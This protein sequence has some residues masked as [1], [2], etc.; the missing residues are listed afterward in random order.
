M[1]E[2]A[3]AYFRYLDEGLAVAARS[4]ASLDVC[5]GAEVAFCD[6]AESLGAMVASRKRELAFSLGGMGTASTNFYND[7][8]SR[9][10]WAE[11][12]EEVRR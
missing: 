3:A 11:T 12:A 8:Y 2:A 7:A 1:P 6:S 10:G 5:Q 9:Q 4:R